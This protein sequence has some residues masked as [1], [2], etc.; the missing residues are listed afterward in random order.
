MVWR[1]VSVVDQRRDFVVL[2]SCEGANVAE[3]CRRFGISRQTGYRWRAR[4]AAGDASFGD[5]SRRPHHSPGRLPAELEA[6]ILTLRDTHP[7]WGARKLAALIRRDGIVPPAVSSVHQVL[8][9][10]GR[11]A[12]DAAGR[13][14]CRFEHARPNALW[15][16]DF[17]GRGRLASGAW[18]HPLTVIDDHSRYAV[19][20]AACSDERTA[21]VREHLERA[22]RRHGLPDAIYVDNGSPWGGGV[23]GQ[24]TPLRVWLA[25]LG[26]AL[27]HSRPYHPQGR[28]KNER[29]HRSLKAE[30]LDRHIFRDLAHAQGAFDAWRRLYN[31]GRPHQALDFAVPAERYRPAH[32]AFPKILA[33]M[34]YAEGEVLRRVGTTKSYVSFR[35]RLWRVPDAFAGEILAIRPRR[36]EGRFVICFGTHEIAA[37]DLTKPAPATAGNV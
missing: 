9:R 3:L 5:R 36:P 4:F 32:R 21:T 16:M 22:L 27:I 23:P 14:H 30:V 7:A 11:I 8:L 20:L 26:V 1:E 15:Q 18:L 33:P 37:I 19:V 34:V 12:A 35:N 10:H 31:T 28:G 17:K 24:W 29:F 25:K 2:A 13:A 6:R